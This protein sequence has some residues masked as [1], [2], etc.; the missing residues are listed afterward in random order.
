MVGHSDEFYLKKKGKKIEETRGTN[1]TEI[2]QTN[3][4]DTGNDAQVQQKK[5]KE[6]NP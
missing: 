6:K 1:S 2:A 5:F 3:K 4:L